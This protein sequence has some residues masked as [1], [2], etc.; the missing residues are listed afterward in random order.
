MPSANVSNGLRVDSLLSMG[1][2]FNPTIAMSA[3]GF[4]KMDID[5]RSFRVP[6]KRAI[7]QVIAPS[8]GKNFIS[9]GRPEQWTPLADDTV[10][11]KDRDPN[12]KFGSES[13]LRRSG[14]LWKTMQQYNIWTVTTTQAAILS[15][16]DKIWYGALH[17][18]GFGVRA[19]SLDHFASPSELKNMAGGGG[20]YIP[21]RP[22]AVLQDADLDGIARVFVTWVAER[23]AV[24]LGV[25]W[26]G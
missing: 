12:A 24:N 19:S 3:K 21:A 20:V 9:N 13:I 7:Q 4:N 1:F 6:L 11:M 25:K 22:F 16:P 5:I 23:A 15:L 26:S 17:Q 10:M 2:S 18:E 8:I 14:L